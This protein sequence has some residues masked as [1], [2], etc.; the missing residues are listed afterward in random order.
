M[1]IT[2]QAVEEIVFNKPIK[3][4][5]Q[6]LNAEISTDNSLLVSPPLSSLENTPSPGSTIEKS[7]FKSKNPPR[8]TLYPAR[9]LTSQEFEKLA[10]KQNTNHLGIPVKNRDSTSWIIESDKKNLQ[11]ELLFRKYRKHK[12]M[13]KLI[14]EDEDSWEWSSHGS[15]PNRRVT[16]NE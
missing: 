14:D 13:K 8:S 6:L 3:K 4:N 11:N 12:I 9:Y 10:K 15:S 1:K 7:G 2:I 16:F 5:K